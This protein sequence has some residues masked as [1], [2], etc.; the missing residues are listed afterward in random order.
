VELLIFLGL[1][2]LGLFAVLCLIAFT[3]IVSW[4]LVAGVI[5]VGLKFIGMMF[6]ITDRSEARPRLV[7][8]HLV[9]KMAINM[10][11]RVEPASTQ[12]YFA[13]IA[14]G[15][16]TNNSDRE[17]SGM[18]VWCRAE[19]IHGSDTE[20]GS[21]ELDLKPG[22]TKSFSGVVSDKLWSVTQPGKSLRV[23]P[24]Q[25]FCRVVRVFEK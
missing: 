17:I 10:N 14:S 5:F 16:I 6:G 12:E 22:E 1:V 11:T 25:H 13:I 9:A 23:S 15:Q 21:I 7:S 4:L 2:L 18:S 24:R 8:E 19:A 20:S 3:P